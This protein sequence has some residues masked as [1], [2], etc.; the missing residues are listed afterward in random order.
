MKGNFIQSQTANSLLVVDNLYD[1][2]SDTTS[3]WV[4][5]TL[6][7]ILEHRFDPWVQC[8]G[9]LY[10]SPSRV[11]KGQFLAKNRHFSQSQRTNIS[12]IIK[13]FDYFVS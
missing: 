9:R 8:H 10:F 5:L 13:R 4:R 12:T 6:N 7:M 3:E 11:V 2:S 1:K